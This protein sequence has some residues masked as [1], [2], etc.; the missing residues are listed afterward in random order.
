MTIPPPAAPPAPGRMAADKRSTVV[1]FRDRLNQLIAR[2]GMSRARFAAEAGLDRSTLT[3][4]LAAEAVRLPRAETIARIAARHGVSADWLLG[5]S[6]RDQVAVDIVAQP[7]IEPD[8]GSPADERLA[9]WHTEARGLKVR[10]VPAT[11]P[12][13]VKT[14]AVIAW[15]TGK[16]A[17]PAARAWSDVARA[18]IAHASRADSEI[19]VCSSRQALEQFARGGGIW[20][21][22]D[23]AVRHDQL[24]RIARL[25]NDLYPAYRWFLFDG[26]ERFSVPYTVF[27]RQRAAIYLGDMY[28]VFT[29]TEHIRELTS[30]FDNLIRAARVQPPD[31]AAL[32]RRLAGE[33]T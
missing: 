13:Q 9:R 22:L 4:L 1:R 32:A 17:A 12:D 18:R 8:A 25:A 3:Q 5:L 33:C 6:E 15:E 23:A 30:H 20:H 27:G 11:L 19:E 2:T 26:R 7:V 24:R 14:E 28:F 31:V 21:G 10:Y 29:S 16:L